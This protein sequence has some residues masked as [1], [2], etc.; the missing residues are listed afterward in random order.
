MRAARAGSINS[1]SLA[2]KSSGSNATS[3]STPRSAESDAAMSGV[4]TTGF[5]IAIASSTLFWIPRA[6]RAREASHRGAGVHTHD[7]EARRWFLLADSR[8]HLARE[9]QD[10]VDVGPVVHRAGEDD[11]VLAGSEGRIELGR[12]REVIAVHAVANRLHTSG[13]APRHVL[14]PSRFLVRHERDRI[15]MRCDVPFESEQPPRLARVKCGGWP[16][17]LPGIGVPLGR[18]GVDEIDDAPHPW[19]IQQVLR[20]RRRKSKGPRDALARYGRA[21]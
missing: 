11:R 18:V 7:I 20:H 8:Q 15:H 6:T 12:R 21:H 16:R 19:K 13:A 4:A 9:P 14:E 5:A 1:R 10:G 3:I 2:A 17:P